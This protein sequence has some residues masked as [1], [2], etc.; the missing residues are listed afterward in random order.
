MSTISMRTVTLYSECEPPDTDTVA[1][2]LDKIEGRILGV[3][4]ETFDRYRFNSRKQQPDESVDTYVAAL[5]LMI[6]QC[7][8]TANNLRDSLI[9][10]RIVMGISD[11]TTLARLLQTPDLTLRACIDTCRTFEAARAQLQSISNPGSEPIWTA[12]TPSRKQE[13]RDRL[14]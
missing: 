7:K 1:Q 6:D 5:R 3:R 10:D 12:R 14:T 13:T 4:S 11:D 8:Y 2:I 9:R